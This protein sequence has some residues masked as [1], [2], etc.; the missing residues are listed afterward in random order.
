MR[1][2]IRVHYGESSRVYSLFKGHF[3]L[4]ISNVT[5]RIIIELC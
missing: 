5:N 3:I 2:T 4:S 1:K